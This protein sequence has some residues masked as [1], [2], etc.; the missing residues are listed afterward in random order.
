MKS[1]SEALK[2]SLLFLSIV[3][4]ALAAAQQVHTVEDPDISFSITIPDDWS[5][6]DDGLTLAIVPPKGGEEYL[7][8][9]YYETTETDID[10]AFEFSVLAMNGPD[11]METEILERGKGEVDSVPARWA[12][13]SLEVDGV[14]YHRLTY[15]LIKHGQYF[16]F[17]GS[18][19]PANFDYFRPIFESA[20]KSLKTTP[21]P[22]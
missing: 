12:I 2:C 14:L 6:Y 17:K 19:E 15:L 9:T 22:K 1:N 3:F 21:A 7:D 4:S 18:A 16:I 10:K 8:F 11:A 5:V 20:I 13:V